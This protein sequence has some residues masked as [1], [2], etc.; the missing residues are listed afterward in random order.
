[1][2]LP[3]LHGVMDKFNDKIKFVW[4]NILDIIFPIECLGCKQEG[5]WICKDC[6]KTVPVNFT[7]HCLE[8]KQETDFGEF[9]RECKN[10]YNLDGVLI[11]SD[12]NNKLVAQA[13]KTL[14][15]RFAYD[16]GQELARL[17]I[18]FIEQE[19]GQIKSAEWLNSF[20]SARPFAP[21]I[22]QNMETALIMPV[23]L[24][25]R[26]QRWRGFNQAEILARQ[27]AEHFRA[28]LEAKNLQRIRPTRDQ[29]SLGKEDRQSN[30]A[31]SFAWRGENLALKNIILVDD[32]VTTGATLESCAAV[33]KEAGAG[34]VWGLVVAKG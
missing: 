14:K 13:I 27:V 9:C 16:I 18:L 25:P 20:L 4:Q 10:K 11:A 21:A 2:A 19:Q 5:E 29:A 8:C 23:P 3:R 24:Y 34:E 30:V 7:S 6:L 22:L 12:Y 1:M 33:L 17:L 26:R 32:V 15:Y 31:D 28:T